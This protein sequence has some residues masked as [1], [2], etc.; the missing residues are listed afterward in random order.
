MILLISVLLVYGLLKSVRID[1]YDE[2]KKGHGVV[3]RP[4]LPPH[5][6]TPA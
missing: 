4:P 5:T 1:I 6:L 3:F 2:M